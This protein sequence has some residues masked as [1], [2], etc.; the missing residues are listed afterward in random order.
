MGI[1]RGMP[2]NQ[3]LKSY[4]LIIESL[5][6]FINST[7]VE[8][9]IGLEPIFTFSW[10]CIWFYPPS[11]SLFPSTRV[12]LGSLLIIPP[13]SYSTSFHA[14]SAAANKPSSLSPTEHFAIS[15]LQNPS[16]HISEL[17]KF[18]EPQTLRLSKL[19]KVWSR[20]AEA[21]K[22]APWPGG[23]LLQKCASLYPSQLLLSPRVHYI[24][25]MLQC[26]GLG[27]RSLTLETSV[28]SLEPLL[29]S[30]GSL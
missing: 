18:A 21:R 22:T 19:R 11:L 15:G 29:S 5:L 16:I 3:Y 14:C 8:S 12:F 1:Q 30:C 20:T 27:L 24:T 28:L 10:S 25:P 6:A 23:Q 17:P 4:E 7:F 26:R 2:I 13:Y 9:A